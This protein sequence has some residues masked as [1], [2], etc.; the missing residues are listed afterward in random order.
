MTEF[1]R[2]ELMSEK[3]TVAL[4]SFFC[5]SAHCWIAPSICRRLLMQA[6][7]CEVV[8]ALIKLGI[9]MAA[10]SP[11]IATTIMIST[12]VKPE[13]RELLIF[14]ILYFS[15]CSRREPTTSEFIFIAM[16]PHIACCNRCRTGKQGQC[17]FT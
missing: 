9:A 5:S 4:G 2:Y 14:F 10:N 13:L 7:I 8:R 16:R 11:M 15:F 3:A 17:Q 1:F 12:N 6:F